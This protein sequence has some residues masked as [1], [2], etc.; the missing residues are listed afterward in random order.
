[1]KIAIAIAVICLLSVLGGQIYFLFVLDEEEYKKNQQESSLSGR[2]DCGEYRDRCCARD[3]RLFL[4]YPSS[5]EEGGSEAQAHT[6]RTVRCGE[7]FYF[8]KVK[9]GKHTLYIEY[10]LSESD[11]VVVQ[12]TATVEV[13]SGEHNSLGT[14]LLSSAA[15]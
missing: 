5:G 15:R 13:K 14:L 3:P 11:P 1:M 12:E 7:F 4:D 2:L 8:E 6:G 9:P 10:R